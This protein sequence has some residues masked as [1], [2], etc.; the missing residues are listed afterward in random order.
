MLF[1][2]LASLMILIVLAFIMPPLWKLQ[3]LTPSDMDAR[4]IAI[5]KNRLAELNE[6][7]HIGALDPAHYEAQRAELELALS[8]DL[9]I[10]A[11]DQLA[12]GQARWIVFVLAVF[13]PLL[14]IGLYAGL[15]NYQAIA[16]T[17]EMLA[18]S[19][20]EPS[21]ED[22]NKMVNKLAERMQTEPDNAEGWLMLGKSYQYLQ[23]YLK[24]VD[25]FAH[26]YQLIGDRAD[27]LLL[28][29]DA[30]AYSN[31][32]QLAGKPTE[33][34]FK[35]LELE[36][37]N[38]TGLWLGG[39]A[40][41]QAGD[42]AAGV[43]L[44][45]K[46]ITLLPPNSPALQ[47]AQQLL[48]KLESQLPSPLPASPANEVSPPSHNDL[49]ISIQVRLAPDVQ[50]SV[51]PTDTVFIYAQALTGPQMPLAV[52]RK[53]VADLPITIQLTD[54]LAMMPT[55]KLSNFAKVKLL[56]RVSKTGNAISQ[57]GDFIGM[58]DNVSVTDNNPKQIEIDSQVK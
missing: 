32:E 14:A 24:A 21:I 52:V 45:R 41:A 35:A 12:T 4:N 26:A 42:A 29:A 2:L 17:P 15:G 5:A 49:A 43:K 47:E 7:L 55:M 46:L 8:D 50:K 38:I 56:A 27:I 23:Q 28:Y 22:V 44:W 30:L 1:W 13:I 10:P 31:G 20:A 19:A 11:Q 39:M 53:Q 25:A 18:T 16:P 9:D 57:P 54:A 48:T 51:A 40:K 6:Q 37:E 34:I 33:L 36:P 58:I 3:Q